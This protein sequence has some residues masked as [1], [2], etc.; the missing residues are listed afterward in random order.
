MT[1]ANASLQA[2]LS[3][4][5]QVRTGC[6][7]SRP[8]QGGLNLDPACM[9]PAGTSFIG[10]Q[11][12][13]WGD[14]H[15]HHLL[16]ALEQIAV[17]DHWRVKVR[18]MPECPPVLNYSPSLAGIHRSIGCERFNDDVLAEA[19]ATSGTQ[20]ATVLMSSRWFAYVGDEVSLKAVTDGLN[21]ALDQL[22]ENG[23]AVILV[24]PGPSLPY[25]VPACLGRREQAE[26]STGRN[27][28]ESARKRSLTMLVGA[29]K[30]RSTVQIFDPF[31][32]LCSANICASAID[33]KVIYSDSH[34]LSVAGSVRLVPLLSKSIDHARRVRGAAAADRAQP[35]TEVSHGDVSRALQATH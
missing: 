20:P 30:D 31:D 11:L 1:P 22:A 10:A 23:F 5:R 25:D 2:S 14:S 12:L 34:H 28:A 15:A 9:F 6:A 35:L 21:A 4:L 18:F 17:E 8:Y 27:E 33:G 3:E 26:C 32:S 19:Q 16:P 24:A 29:A 7:Q 13:L